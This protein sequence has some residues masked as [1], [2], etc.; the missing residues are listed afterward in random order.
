MALHLV[1]AAF[2][3]MVLGAVVAAV[4]V[5]GLEVV[6]CPEDLPNSFNTLCSTRA[7]MQLFQTKKSMLYSR[8]MFRKLFESYLKF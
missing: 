6:S 7:C 3:Y 4:V 5:V 2:P 1:E 8:L